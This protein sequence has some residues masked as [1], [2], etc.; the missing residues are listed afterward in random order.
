MIGV[1]CWL[2]FSAVPVSQTQRVGKWDR[3]RM[4]YYWYILRYIAKY[5]FKI[6]SMNQCVIGQ[7]RERLHEAQSISNIVETWRR[8]IE[9]AELV[10]RIE[11]LENVNERAKEAN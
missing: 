5:Y 6:L 4:Q 8:S 9:T 7:V 10:E 3:P 2:L 11:V 1:Q